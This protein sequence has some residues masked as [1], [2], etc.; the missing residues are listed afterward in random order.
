MKPIARS[1]GRTFLARVK[2]LGRKASVVV[3]VDGVLRQKND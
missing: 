3:G 1:V 2:V